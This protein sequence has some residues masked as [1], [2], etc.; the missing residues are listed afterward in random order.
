MQPSPL[1]D[2]KRVKA[3]TTLASKLDAYMATFGY[4]Q[5]DIPI[6]QS[7]DLFLTK[8][9]DQ[10]I[11]RLFTFERRGQL[12]A[13]RPEFTA[14]AAHA[15]LQ[16]H[17]NGDQIVRWQFQGA[18]FEDD[19]YQHDERFSIGA[20][21]IGHSGIEADAEVIA[22]ATKGLE[23]AGVQNSQIIIGHVKLLRLLLESFQL[24]SRTI[25]FLMFHLNDLNDP[26]RG[27]A[28]VLEQIDELLGS[29]IHQ[30]DAPEH[31]IS[32]TTNS[33]IALNTQQILDVLL[34]ATQ[35]GATMGGRTRH[36]I[37][38]RLLQKH[39][40][41]AERPQIV[42]ALEF[43]NAYASIDADPAQAFP[44]IMRIVSNINADLI[45]LVEE[46][47]DL[48]SRVEAQGVALNK[49]HIKPSLS[50][51][52]DYYT[53]I[54]FEMRS[55]QGD[56]LGGGGRYDELAR[57]LNSKRDIPAVGFA[58]YIDDILRITSPDSGV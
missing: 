30:A 41:A 35:R 54:L 57:L 23:I 29:N 44:E 50:R 2:A 22:M 37:V 24:D 46:W 43:L 8:A 39:Q 51:N 9:G 15:Y 1:L 5:F 38:K 21:L 12:L 32:D 58:Y 45:A 47:K 42:A 25:R 19:A 20:E 40:R 10:I 31:V 11:N 3:Q 36:D 4:D 49:I 52:W 56:H 55:V 34:D 28:Y 7:A 18:V 27:S 14:S 16:R 48:I 26:L 17:P 33:L 53:G 13:L 6:I